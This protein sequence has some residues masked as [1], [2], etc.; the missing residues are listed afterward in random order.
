M[1]WGNVAWLAC[2]CAY[3][4]WA[5]WLSWH[6]LSSRRLPDRLTLPA[7]PVA[8]LASLYDD[9]FAAFAAYDLSELTSSTS[10]QAM[11]GAVNPLECQRASFASAG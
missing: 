8:A 5:A 6:D 4:V 11:L 10:T 7:V 1:G 2:A 9:S 3:V